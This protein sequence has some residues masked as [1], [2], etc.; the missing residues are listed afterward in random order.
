M[1][2]A[3]DQFNLPKLGVLGSCLSA[4]KAIIVIP[5]FVVTMFALQP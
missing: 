5:H 4:G 1:L 3:G 2:L